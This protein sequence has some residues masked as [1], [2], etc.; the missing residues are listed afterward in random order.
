MLTFDGSPDTYPDRKKLMLRFRA[1]ML[2][3]V[4]TRASHDSHSLAEIGQQ[5]GW[6]ASAVRFSSHP[7]TLSYFRPE[8]QGLV[9]M[10]QHSNGDRNF[11]CELKVCVDEGDDDDDFRTD[12]GEDDGIP[13]DCE[14]LHGDERVDDAYL[15]SSVSL[16]DAGQCWHKI[17]NSP[18][19]V[20][21][22]PILRRP[23]SGRETGLEMPLDMMMALA[24]ASVPVSYQGRTFVKGH[25]TALVPTRHVDGLTI[26]HFVHNDPGIRISINDPRLHC[27]DLF[28]ASILDGKRHILGWCEKAISLTGMQIALTRSKNGQSHAHSDKA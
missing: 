22:Y 28:D 7:A 27:Y 4:A 16:A 20:T 6:L 25:S 1:G 2:E 19:V 13:V 5:L 8:I 24:D 11:L 15:E 18:V 14:D 3:A 9:F 10:E 12:S 21:G 23:E 17:F 26:W